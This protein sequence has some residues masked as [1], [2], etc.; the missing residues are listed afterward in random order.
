MNDKVLI[1]SDTKAGHLNQSLAFCKLKNLSYDI[2]SL[3]SVSKFKKVLSYVLDFL[4]IYINLFG[5]KA[6]NKKYK[7]II[8]TG[9]NTYYMNKY[10]AKMFKIKSIAIM[11]PKGFRYSDFDYII[12]QEHD[13]PPKEANIITMPLNLSFSTPLGYVKKTQQKAVGIIIGGNNAI[14]SMDVDNIKLALDEIN[15]KFPE[16]LKY[17]TTSRRTPKEVEELIEKYHFDYEVIFSKNISI[18]P[19]PDFIEVCDEL[20]ITID[21]TSMLSEAKAN[22][23]ANIHIIKLESKKEHTKY[24]KLASIIENIKGQFDYM[25]YLNKVK[26]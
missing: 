20:Y 19:I 6:E 26:I 23:N 8:S 24:H 17:I 22:S 11:L 10:L 5:L 12:A 7:A 16:H 2:I 3:E 25:T 1:L 9:S 13:F 4:H 21:S 15:E 18:N 14:F